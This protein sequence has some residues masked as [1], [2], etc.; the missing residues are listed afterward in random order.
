MPDISFPGM[1]IVVPY[2]GSTPEEMEELV[3]RPVEE[4]LA[5]LSGIKEIRASAQSDQA[6]FTVLFDW[7]RDV[8]AAAFEVRT[9]LDSIRP[10]LPDGAT[11][12]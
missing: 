2:A 7:D 11:G 1:Q 4:A 5:T 8:D 3:V 6:T 9:K 10:Q 12:C